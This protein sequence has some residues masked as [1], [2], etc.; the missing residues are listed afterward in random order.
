MIGMHK[1][2]DVLAYSKISIVTGRFAIWIA[3]LALI[4]FATWLYSMDTIN[5]Q[6]TLQINSII[7]TLDIVVGNQ[8]SSQTVQTQMLSTDARVIALQEQQWDTTRR[9]LDSLQL[10]LNRLDD[11]IDAVAQRYGAQR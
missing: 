7:K 5:I 8:V 1:A 11:K 10:Q 3:S 6:Q 9:V 4:P 2:L